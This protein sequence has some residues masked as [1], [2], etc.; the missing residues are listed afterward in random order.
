MQVKALAGLGLVLQLPH[1]TNNCALSNT[2][3]LQKLVQ[4][5]NFKTYLL[6]QCNV[7][8]IVAKVPKAS[9][10]LNKNASTDLSTKCN[11]QLI[12]PRWAEPRGIQ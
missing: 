10:D 5:F 1:S 7:E 9:V 12:I 2:L 8:L 6:V 11:S 3:L 4:N